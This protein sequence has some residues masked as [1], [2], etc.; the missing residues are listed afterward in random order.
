MSARVVAAVCGVVPIHK[1]CIPD[2]LNVVAVPIVVR[3]VGIA[4]GSNT[5]R[6]RQYGCRK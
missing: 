4:S 5:V 1:S 6:A 2:A 3:A